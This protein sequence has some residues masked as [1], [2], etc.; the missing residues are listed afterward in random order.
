MVNC[1]YK[2]T[3]AEKYNIKYVP[4]F[5]YEVDGKII[6]RKTGTISQGAMKAMCRDGWF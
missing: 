6:R 2:R 4:T 5:I 1:G 3:K